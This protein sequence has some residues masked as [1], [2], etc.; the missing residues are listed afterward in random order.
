MWN[1]HEL[2][3]VVYMYSFLI[4]SLSKDMMHVKLFL[5]F[6]NVTEGKL[7]QIVEK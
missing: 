6:N 4:K 7:L 5:F 1:G 3:T 2:N